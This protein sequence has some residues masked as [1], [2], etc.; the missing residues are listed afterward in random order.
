MSFHFGLERKEINR[1]GLF[2]GIKNKEIPIY[3]YIYICIYIYIYYSN[4][5][6]QRALDE[7]PVSSAFAV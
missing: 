2:F 4:G 6:A 3:I 5:K 7:R 1:L